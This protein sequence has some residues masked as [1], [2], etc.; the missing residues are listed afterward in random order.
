L[1][2]PDVDASALDKIEGD[3]RKDFVG[4]SIY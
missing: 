3:D 4:N 2:L 1:Q